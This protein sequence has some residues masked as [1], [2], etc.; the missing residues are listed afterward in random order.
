[1]DCKVSKNKQWAE[2]VKR[3]VEQLHRVELK[4]TCREKEHQ[5]KCEAM[6]KAMEDALA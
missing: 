2:E 6:W 3:M 4:E 5:A 1:M